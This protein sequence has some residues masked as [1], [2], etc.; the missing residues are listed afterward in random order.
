MKKSKQVTETSILKYS[1]I[2]CTIFVILE[3]FT[4]VVSQS[5]SVLMDAVYDA[6]EIFMIFISIKVLPLLYKP[7]SEKHPYGY[8][9][10]ESVLIILKGFMMLSVTVGLL[11]NNIQIMI[12]GGQHV[13]YGEVAIFELFISLVS[14]LVAFILKKQ[15][16][17][18]NSPII[19]TEIKGWLIDAIASLGMAISFITPVIFKLEDTNIVAYLDQ[20]VAILLCLSILPYPIKL[21]ITT[22]KDIFLFA[23]EEDTVNSIKEICEDILPHD[24][25][26]NLTYDIIRTGRKLWIS[27]YFEPIEENISTS[28]LLETQ[29]KLKSILT[30][31]Y[32]DLYLEILPDI[33]IPTKE[34]NHT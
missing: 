26:N 1:M 11:I 17:H 15:N 3:I 31:T 30:D 32:D 34:E 7:I 29:I 23:P 19:T 27:I 4:S 20:V 6:T 21:L 9:Q 25:S 13:E 5:Q 8:S 12:S 28:R 14:F 2:A 24:F 10:L 33:K 16:K 22:F 18:F